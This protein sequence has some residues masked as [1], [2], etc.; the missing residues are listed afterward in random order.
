VESSEAGYITGVKFYKADSSATH[1]VSFWD[2]SGN[3]LGT[4]TS[5]SE[6]GAGWQSVA[7][8]N[9]VAIA[10]N[11]VYVASYYM[12]GGSFALTR[13]GFT[14]A[15][16]NAPLEALADGQDGGNGVYAYGPAPSFPNSSL[17]ASN[18]WVDVLF[19]TTPPASSCTPS[20]PCSIWP[21]SATPAGSQQTTSVEL[22]VKVQSSEAGYVTGIN[23]YKADSSATHA[24][25]LWDGSGDL[26]GTSTS[27][28]ETSS[29]WQ[30]VALSTPVAIAAN[31][32]YV[33]SYHMPGGS[34]AL[35]RPGFTTAV[36]NTPLEALADGQD[37]GNGVYA[38]GSTPSFP[39]SSL[40]ASNYWV[41]V[42]FST[43]P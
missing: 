17:Q 42:L 11:T 3:L 6:T 14:T 33:A 5:T 29:G 16:V 4:A 28:G 8:S 35:T 22:G 39:N 24:V 23:F 37:G 26:L 9:P 27:T 41:D 13:P 43:T 40:Q 34:F 38:Y 30:S 19:S 21:A 12:S 7:L 20:Q 25:S 1:A 32:V 36:V 18:Y 2:G 10:A 15:V 31:T